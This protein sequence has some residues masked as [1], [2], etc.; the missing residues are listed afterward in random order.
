MDGVKWRPWQG[1]QMEAVVFGD[2][3]N[4]ALR[5]RLPFDEN[6]PAF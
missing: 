6:F 5:V 2:S 4:F 1:R 3:Y